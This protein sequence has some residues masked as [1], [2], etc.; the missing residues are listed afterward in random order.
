MFKLFKKTKVENAAEFE[1]MVVT[2]P[3]SGKEITISQLVNDMDEMEKKKDEPQMADEDHMIN[4]GE[5]A[6]KMSIKD[7]KNAYMAMKQELA[8]MKKPKE[9]APKENA[10][11]DEEKKKKEDEA[12]KNAEDEAAKKAEDE[13]KK[14]E[15]SE[16]NKA[17]NAHY[18]ALKNAPHTAV[19]DQP[20]HELSEDKVERGKARYGS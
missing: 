1:S 12:K 17:K 16:M 9:D 2:L 7:L 11:S 13:K 4:M 15:E 3:K 18:E 19:K 5:G 8:D 6:E 20:I 14:N 10:E